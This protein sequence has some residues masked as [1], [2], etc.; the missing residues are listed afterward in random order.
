MI[1]ITNSYKLFQNKTKFRGSTIQASHSQFQTVFLPADGS[2]HTLV[3]SCLLQLYV[4]DYRHVAGCWLFAFYNNAVFWLIFLIKSY[5]LNCMQKDP[6]YRLRWE[7]RKLEPV[8]TVI[9]GGPEKE[10][11][12]RHEKVRGSS[13]L[14]PFPV[15]QECLVIIS[16]IPQRTLVLSEVWE[17]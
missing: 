10:T 5:S 1:M 4:L 9:S 17:V 2:Q 14:S 11:H 12:V 15:V 8:Q 16:W 3:S 7:S 13:S 6:E